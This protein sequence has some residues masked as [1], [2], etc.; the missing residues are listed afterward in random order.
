MRL[1]TRTSLLHSDLFLDDRSRSDKEQHIRIAAASGS[2]SP[3]TRGPA[4]PQ[5]R[6]VNQPHA[7]KPFYHDHS[8]PSHYCNC[9]ATYRTSSLHPKRRNTNTPAPSHDE[10]YCTLMDRTVPPVVAPSINRVAG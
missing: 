7:L 4:S 9:Q 8:T 3:T 1:H 2:V 6:Q 5:Q 10:L